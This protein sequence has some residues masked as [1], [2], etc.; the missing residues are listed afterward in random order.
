MKLLLTLRWYPN[1]SIRSALGVLLGRGFRESRLV[2]IPTAAVGQAGD[3][4]WLV[5][6][7]NRTTWTGAGSTSWS[8]TAYPRK[9]WQG[10]WSVPM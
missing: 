4:A 5:D 8:S 1:E 10:G 6:D 2:F 9:Y 7:L 3:H